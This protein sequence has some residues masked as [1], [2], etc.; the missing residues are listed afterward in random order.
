MDKKQQEIEKVLQ[1]LKEGEI[2]TENATKLILSYED[3][4]F[5]KLDHNRSS[6]TGFPEVIFGESKTAEQIIKL[7]KSFMMTT[8]RVLVTKVNSEKAE[9]ILDQIDEL[10]YDEPSET[11]VWKKAEDSLYQF[12]GYVAVIS[13]GTSDIPVVNEASITAELFGCKV[14]IINDIGVAGIHRL[15]NHL[16]TIKNATVVIAVAGMEGALPSVVAGLIDRP[17]IAVP[18]SVGYGANLG[19]VSALL[20]MLNSCSP[21]ISVVNIDNGFGAGY[22]AALINKSIHEGVES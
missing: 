22:N 10:R 13:G 9:E 2:T 7:L 3:L 18:T 11:L 1:Q 8:N 19:G 21:G 20:S 12:P 5:A 16:D 6:R 15:F 4:G 14:K 17:L